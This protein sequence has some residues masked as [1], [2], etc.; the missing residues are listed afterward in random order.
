MR[1]EGGTQMRE[2]KYSKSSCKRPGGKYFLGKF[3]PWSSARGSSK[4]VTTSG[5][6]GASPGSSGL[7]TPTSALSSATL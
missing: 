4:L 7:G 1:M 3:L 5:G 2:H 6:G